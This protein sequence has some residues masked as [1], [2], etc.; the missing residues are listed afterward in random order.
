VRFVVGPLASLQTQDFDYASTGAEM[1]FDTSYA[2]YWQTDALPPG[3]TASYSTVYGLG[4][5]LGGPCIADQETQCGT[6]GDDNLEVRNGTV[7]G[8]AGNDII[9]V[10]VDP[11]TG[12]IIADGGEGDD[13][14]LLTIEDPANT[15]PI[16]MFGMEGNDS[17]S[18]PK[19]PGVLEAQIDGGAGNDTMRVY[20]PQ[21]APR[22]ASRSQ[23]LQPPPGRYLFTGGGGSDDVISGIGADVLHGNLGRDRIVGGGG[24]DQ[25][26][27]DDGD[28]ALRGNAGLN[29]FYG[30]RN[31]DTC[32]SDDRRDEFNSCER[33]RRNHRRNHSPV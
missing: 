13:T 6:G 24:P 20:V 22:M 11:Q 5:G 16:R 1:P 4:P 2:L 26:W 12:E 10:I 29:I 15:A 31:N 32:V 9:H 21:A 14:F 19:N 33:V 17:F 8:G 7:R 30:G 28:D 23:K 25:L 18:V 27:G 3:Q